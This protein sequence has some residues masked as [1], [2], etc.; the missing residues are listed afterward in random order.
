MYRE[1]LRSYAFPINILNQNEVSKNKLE[2]IRSRTRKDLEKIREVCAKYK[3]SL[4]PW[5]PNTPPPF[6]NTQNYKLD[7]E[8]KLG[9]CLNAKVKIMVY[10]FIN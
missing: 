9:W 8:K 2:F 7:D 6:L 3:G 4:D 5:L 1:K 10:R